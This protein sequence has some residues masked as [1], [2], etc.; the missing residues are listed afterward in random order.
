VDHKELLMYG[1][2][3]C[4]PYR[5]D[6]S[7]SFRHVSEMFQGSDLTFGQLEAVL[8]LEGV[9]STCTRMPCSSKPELAKVMKRAGFDVISFS[10]NHALDYGRD[11]F[12]ETCQHIRDA[13][14][15]LTGVGENEK[16][17]RTFPVLDIEGT[18]IAVLGYNSILPQGFWAQEARPGCNPARGI[19]AY[20][21]VEHDQ[22]DTTL[23]A[24]IAFPILMI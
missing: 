15:Y 13:G 12:C 21:P 9:L 1:V 10:S 19:T 17:A 7:S 2:G 11:A 22:P 14:L 8:S 18:K 24:C 20:V 5:D 6:L 23:F 4:A 3:D 16:N